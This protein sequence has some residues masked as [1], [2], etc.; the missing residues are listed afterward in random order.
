MTADTPTDINSLGF[1]KPAAETRVVVA[2]SGGV[3]L[4]VGGPQA[5]D[6]HTQ[7]RHH[8]AAYAIMAL[9]LMSKALVALVQ[10]S[11]MPEPSPH[12]LISRIMCLIM[13][14]CLKIR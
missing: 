8:H 3:D 9:R 14:A 6:V 7:D 13:K 2:M 5:K 11:M 10:I 4:S 1:A 12:A